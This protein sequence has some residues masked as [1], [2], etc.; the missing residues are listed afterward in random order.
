MTIEQILGSTNSAEELKNRFLIKSAKSRAA[1]AFNAMSMRF[2]EDIQRIAM[3]IAD[4]SLATN[5]MTCCYKCDSEENSEKIQ[6]SEE[7]KVDD[8]FNGKVF[9]VTGSLEKYTRDEISN[10]IEKY[11]GKVSNSVSK[12]TDYLLAGEAAG[13]KLTKA[14]ELGTTIITESDFEEM[15]K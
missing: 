12:K 14:Q 1:N 15:I 11:S 7:E 8:R 4:G 3:G 2:M 5:G 13:S 10:L 9:V 6:F